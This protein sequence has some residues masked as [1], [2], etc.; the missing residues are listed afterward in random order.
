MAILGY[1]F[2]EMGEILFNILVTLQAIHTGRAGRQQV[3]QADRAGHT[4]SETEIGSDE[5]NVSRKRR[6]RGGFVEHQ[7]LT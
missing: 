7:S 5:A 3:R 1:F 4:D 2:K 6:V